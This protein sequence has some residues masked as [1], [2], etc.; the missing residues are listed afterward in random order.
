MPEGLTTWR[1]LKSAG[2]K[3]VKFIIVDIYGR[4]KLEVLPIDMARDAFI[5]GIAYD[6][7]SIPAYTT[8]NRSDFVAE[9]DPNAVYIETWNEGKTALAFTSTLDGNKPHPMDPRNALKGVVEYA[10]S[11]GYEVKMGSEIEFFIV[12]GNPPSLVDSGAYFEGYP[13]KETFPVIEEIL[14]HFYL[15]GIGLT[16]THHEVAPSQFEINIPAADPV[17]V[18]D[19]IL[20]YKIMAK[21]IAQKHGLTAT[22]MPKPFWGVNGSG[23]HT[24]VSFWKDGVNLF[25]SYKEPTPELKS[26]VAGVLEHAIENSVF[27]APLVNSYKRLVPHYEAPTR[28]VWGIGNR[29]AMVRIPYYA[30]KI[31]RFEY[32]H[33]DPSLNPYLGFAAIIISALDGLERK[34]EPPKPVEE[35][36]YELSGVA[37]TPKHLGEAV[38]AASQGLVAKTLPP[39]LVKAYLGLKEQEW[40][41]Y[42]ATVGS[43]ESTWNSITKWEYD[44]YLD[45]A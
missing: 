40:S 26:A 37:E 34:L 32:R 38:K 44:R 22:F 27:V 4:P 21:A 2:V 31:N 39:S 36:A 5:D 29:S 24:H 13:L 15:S 35:V 43:W 6:G 1:L 23:M 33:P 11:R 12:R 42:S 18:A 17:Q 20:V 14:E 10:K 9:V 28:V 30:N 19:Q 8:V 25:A 3:Y 16:K 45:T 7:S 41:E